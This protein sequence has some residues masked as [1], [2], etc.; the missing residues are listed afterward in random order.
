MS[1]GP[2][3]QLRARGRSTLRGATLVGW[4]AGMLAAVEAHK[5]LDRKL[6]AGD[7]R[8]QDAIFERYMRTW[9][10]VGLE[11]AG[12]EVDASE[13]P[14]PA[15]PPGRAR[16]VVANHRSAVDI[17]ILLTWFGGSVL[18]HAGV[19]A[20][21]LLGTAAQKAQTIFVDRDSKQ[22]GARAIRAI[23]EHLQRGRTINVFPEGTTFAGDEVRPFN[24]GA[25][26]AGRN[27]DL[28]V[29]P[30]GLAYPPGYEFTEPTFLEHA[31]AVARRPG[32]RVA[33]VIG[34]PRPIRGRTAKVAAELRAEVQNLVH[35]ARARYQ[36]P[37]TSRSRV[38][39]A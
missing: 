33:M 5:A 7:P 31:A 34:N 13:G 26:A 10:R 4:T 20:M 27:L 38:R 36:T 2:I 16:L 18:S 21:P 32:T 22:S 14:L 1:P 19:E 28:E 39:V 29:I 24:A 6:R 30:V 11:V 15:P 3:E 8:S 37:G 17:P 12:V 25:F 23:R 9:T 35:R